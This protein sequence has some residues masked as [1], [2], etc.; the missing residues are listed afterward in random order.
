MRA[1]SLSEMVSKRT[2]LKCSSV[3]DAASCCQPWR[4]PPGSNS[5]G[6]SFSDRLPRWALESHHA[7]QGSSGLCSRGHGPPRYSPLHAPTEMQMANESAQLAQNADVLVRVALRRLMPPKTKSRFDHPRQVVCP[8][9]GTMH[10]EQP[11]K[12]AT[13]RILSKRIRCSATFSLHKRGVAEWG[14][15][16]FHPL[17]LFKQTW[18][19]PHRA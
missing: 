3:R 5:S 7:N 13:K 6:G 18:S 14:S 16:D 19:S 10:E 17:P 15:E 2:S 1:R 9:C 11:R 12:S 8:C 4:T